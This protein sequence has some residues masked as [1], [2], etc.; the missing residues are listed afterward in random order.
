[1]QNKE[2]NVTWEKLTFFDTL[3]FFVE[4]TN[5]FGYLNTSLEQVLEEY[6]IEP[7]KIVNLD[8][9]KFNIRKI[10]GINFDCVENK[11]NV[12]FVRIKFCKFNKA[13]L[14]GME[15]QEKIRTVLKYQGY[16]DSDIRKISYMK[17]WSNSEELVWVADVRDETYNSFYPDEDYS[18]RGYE[19]SLMSQIEEVL[20]FVVVINF[21]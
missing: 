9:D 17:Y 18:A 12:F 10:V 13:E 20:G 16:A 1:M 4:T 6:G 21:V 2:F 7:D 3:K 11:E 19:S 8:I 5:V 14:E 15:T